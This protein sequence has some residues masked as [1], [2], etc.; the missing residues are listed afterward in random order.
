VDV[1]AQD[2]SQDRIEL[3]AVAERVVRRPTVA[4]G[5]V[6]ESIRAER[7]RSTIVV[8]ERP[9]DPQQFLLGRGIG[10]VRVVLADLE[11]RQYVLDLLLAVRVEDE[12]LAVLAVAWM[13][14]HAEEALLVLVVAVEHLLLDVEE[15]LRRL[16]LL[17]VGE[18]VDDAVLRG[19]KD[20]IAAV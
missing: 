18:Y 15:D 10:T 7:D 4:Q 11:A 12:E 1:D 20:A 17:V 16:R 6:Q 13:E 2:F 14:R 9:L 5:H 19:Q 3:L 8:P